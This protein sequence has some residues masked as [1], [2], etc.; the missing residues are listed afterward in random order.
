[1]SNKSYVS[2]HSVLSIIFISNLNVGSMSLDI[3]ISFAKGKE[4]IFYLSISLQI[5]I[6]IYIYYIY[7][8]YIYINVLYINVLNIYIYVYYIY[9]YIYIYL[10]YIYIY[11][12]KINLN[13]RQKIFFGMVA[14]NIFLHNKE[15]SVA[16]DHVT[17]VSVIIQTKWHQ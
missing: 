6:Y 16:I 5:Y 10:T 3:L 12:C 2:S 17:A 15:S 7:V 9:I 8:Q 4:C 1:M 11:S 13:R 14:I